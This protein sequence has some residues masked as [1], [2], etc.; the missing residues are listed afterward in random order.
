MNDDDETDK[1]W[2]AEKEKKLIHFS[3]LRYHNCIF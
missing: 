2:S 1:T 3:I